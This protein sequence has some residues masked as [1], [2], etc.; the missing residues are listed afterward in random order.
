MDLAGIGYAHPLDI[1]LSFALPAVVGQ[2]LGFSADGATLGAL[3]GYLMSVLQH[4][5]VRTPVWLGYAVV[6]PEAHGLHHARGIHAYN[7]GT[8]PLWDFVF[9]T[10]RNPAGFPRHYGFWDG[11]SARMGAMLV[12]RDLTSVSPNE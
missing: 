10:Y 12:G 8:C 9:G 11:A 7:Y 6:R 1:L 2:M 3:L 4:A 5:N